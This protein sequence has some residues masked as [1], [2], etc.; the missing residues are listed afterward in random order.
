MLEFSQPD[1]WFRPF[2]Y[3][4]LKYLLPLVAAVATGD[5]GAY[6]Y[7]AGTIE[8][9]PTKQALG[10]Q[11]QLAGFDRVDAIGLT[12]SIVAVHHATKAD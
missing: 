1:R 11:I 6:D 4:Y 8:H 9:F 2:Y 10:E 5:K 3:A 12:F 7:L